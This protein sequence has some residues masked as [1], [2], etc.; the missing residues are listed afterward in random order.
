MADLPTVEPDGVRVVDEDR[1]D[2]NLAGPCN[3]GH[4]AGLDAGDI[5]HDAVDG[6]ARVAECGLC[7]G[8]VL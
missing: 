4:K 2:R 1:E 6:D 5:G 7:Y 3:D 8:V